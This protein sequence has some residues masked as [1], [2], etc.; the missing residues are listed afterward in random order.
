MSSLLGIDFE[1]DVSTGKVTRL[2]TNVKRDKVVELLTEF[3]RGQIGQGADER[4]AT[5]R[6]RYAIKIRLD[7]ADDQFS[8]SSDCGNY[9]LRDGIIMAAITQLT[10]GEWPPEKR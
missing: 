9:G 7:L 4:Q 8:S 1:Y 5:E 6:D 2:T 3:L 10:A